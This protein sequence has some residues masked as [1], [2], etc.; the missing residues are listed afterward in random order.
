[1]GEGADAVPIRVEEPEAASNH[2]EGSLTTEPFPNPKLDAVH[3]P[4]GHNA[5]VLLYHP[6]E[7][8]CDGVFANDAVGVHLE[9]VSDD[10]DGHARDDSHDDSG[11]GATRSL[12]A[13]VDQTRSEPTNGVL[14]LL[15]EENGLL[16]FAP[17]RDAEVAHGDRIHGKY[18]AVNTLFMTILTFCAGCISTPFPE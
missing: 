6:V 7:R 10:V 1:M 12:A 11:E 5:I 16:V 2:F 3:R 14:T 9:D 15:N 13:S 17:D 18:R 4:L 8:V